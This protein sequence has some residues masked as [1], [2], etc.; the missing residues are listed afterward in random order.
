M[1]RSDMDPE[2]ARLLSQRSG[3]RAQRKRAPW[4]LQCESP[5]DD[6]YVL[7]GRPAK[8]RRR[9][10]SAPVPQGGH[11]D[12][13][14]SP[15]DDTFT[16]LLDDEN[17]DNT[18]SESDSPSNGSCINL[19]SEEE[20]DDDDPDSPDDQDPTGTSTSVLLGGAGCGP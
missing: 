18:D 19:L 12:E 14:H 5:D 13:H 17:D 8:R 4:A 9:S 2:W 20:E 3:L 10:M 7:R 6:E 11:L 15:S 1:Q 16:D